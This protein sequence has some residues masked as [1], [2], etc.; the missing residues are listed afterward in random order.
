MDRDRSFWLRPLEL[1]ISLR[2]AWLIVVILAFAMMLTIILVMRVREPRWTPFMRGEALASKLGCFACHE[3]RGL[4][5]TPNL[6]SDLGIVPPISANGTMM[7]YAQNDEEIRQWISNGAPDRLREQRIK[8]KDQA[9]LR[10]P[11]YKAFISEANLMDL[12]AYVK[13]MAR[14]QLDM[15]PKAAAG[16]KLALKFGCFGC[17][18]PFGLGG[19]SNPGSFKGY[20]PPWDGSDFLEIVRDKKELKEWILNGAIRRFENNPVARY[21]TTLQVIKMPAYKQVLKPGEL[22]SLVDYITWLRKPTRKKTNPMIRPLQNVSWRQSRVERGEWL[23]R[24]TGCSSC[25]GIAGAGGIFNKNATGQRVPSLEDFAE[26]LG[27]LEPADAKTFLA[28]IEQVSD[29]TEVKGKAPFDG[30][31]EVQSMYSKMR[32]LVLRGSKPIAMNRN[33]PDPPIQMPG[34]SERLGADSSPAS[35]ED[36]DSIL[37]YIITLQAWPE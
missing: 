23:Y 33:L 36:V 37:A 24:S 15:T 9:Q 16:Y 6:N 21:F 22:D 31:T 35:R 17:H 26:R 12:T 27:I 32:D 1:L 14:Q 3:T 30:F 4:G 34:W 25:H 19:L 20:I 10:M 13:G 28:M 2:F 5:S 8:L 11:A 29:I 7:F 18:G